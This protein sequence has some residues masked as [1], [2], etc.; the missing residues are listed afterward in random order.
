MI[1]PKHNLHKTVSANQNGIIVSFLES[2]K[3][4]FVKYDSSVVKNIQL[5]GTSK[6]QRTERSFLNKTQQAIYAQAVYGLTYFTKE[7]LKQMKPERKQ[8]IITHHQRVQTVLNVWKQ[9][10]SNDM[11]D[12]Y[13]RTLY[14]KS[15]VIMALLATS[16]YD[17]TIEDKQ[18]F[19][20][21]GITQ[22][23]IVE[24]LLETGL[25]PENFMKIAV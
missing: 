4:R 3:H 5:Y 7:Q 9:K 25:L 2:N 1:Q 15:E 14:Q 17:H 11:V 6:Y 12:N 8:E 24:K 23:M 22:P 10:L 19:K 20:D 13:L 16:G 21:L 18:T